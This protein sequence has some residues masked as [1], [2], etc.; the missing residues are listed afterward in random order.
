[1]RPVRPNAAELEALAAA[2]DEALKG[3]YFDKLWRVGEQQ[4]LVKLSSGD[5]R[6]VLIDA[7]AMHPRVTLT[8]RWPETPASPDRVAL[9]L[10]KFASGARVTRVEAADERAL[11]L[12]LTRGGEPLTL[13][14]QLA[15][16]YP[17]AALFDAEGTELVRLLSG[18]EARDDQSPSLREGPAPA[19][20]PEDWLAAWDARGWAAAD[21]YQVHRLQ[22]DL[23]RALR[24]GLKKLRKKAAAIE[25]DL[26]KAESADAY[27]HQGE[28]LKTAL[29]RIERGAS[30]VAVRDW[31]DPEGGHTL[32]P[33]DPALSPVENMER[34]FKKYRKF[35]G[36]RGRIEALML[37][38]LEAIEVAEALQTRLSAIELP[39]APTRQEAEAATAELQALEADLRRAGL[40]RKRQQQRTGRDA[41]ALPYHRFVSAD[42]AEI[43]VGRGARHNDALTFK[44]GRGNDVWLHA[45]DYPGS[46]VILRCARGAPPHPRALADAALLAAWHSKARGEPLVDVMWTYRKHVRKPRGAN[47]GAVTVADSKNLAVRLG[48]DEANAALERLYAARE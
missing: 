42:G 33:L 7:E 45:R 24:G 43:L 3:R 23:A 9:E 18:R 15:G 14:V 38:Q 2:L 10:R 34:Y 8:S 36:A 6:R 40:I 26:D 16:R 32:V 4:I 28:L 20:G 27:R 35:H 25:R 1:M 12:H 37:E 29:G 19:E 39:E 44:V 13:R 46:H 48:D 17:N 5:K 30:E 47:P 22:Q 31:S 21:R 11:V 41:P